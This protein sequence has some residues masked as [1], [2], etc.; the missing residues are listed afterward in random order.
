MPH[1]V[2]PTVTWQVTETGDTSTVLIRPLGV[3]PR[4]RPVPIPADIDRV[5]VRVCGAYR[6]GVARVLV[7]PRDPR[8]VHRTRVLVHQLCVVLDVEPPALLQARTPPEGYSARVQTLK[9]LT[10]RRPDAH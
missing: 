4:G 2:R 8:V 6:D 3:D 9:S 10:R 5:L 1:L 7:L